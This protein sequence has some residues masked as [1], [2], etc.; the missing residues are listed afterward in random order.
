MID[1]SF[2]EA[3][4]VSESEQ[5]GVFSSPISLVHKSNLK[6]SKSE[7]N[8]KNAKG[9]LLLTIITAASENSKI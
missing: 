1:Q 7:P 6:L 9:N 2:N 3:T 8:K 5:M 4:L